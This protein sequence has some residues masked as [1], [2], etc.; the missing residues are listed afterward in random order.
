MADHSAHGKLIDNKNTGNILL[1]R[2]SAQDGVRV[3]ID[4]VTSSRKQ[5][6]DNYRQDGERPKVLARCPCSSCEKTRHEDHLE[7]DQ[8]DQQKSIEFNHSERLL[9]CP[10]KVLAF[11]L[12]DKSWRYVKVSELRDVKFRD[13]AFKNLVIKGK[14]KTVVKAMVRS[15]LSKEPGFTDLIHGKG[16]GLVL[17]LH[18]SPGTGK[19]LTAG[20]L[21]LCLLLRTP[22]C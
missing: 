5:G 18:G 8:V 17:L 15:Y 13:D 3:M 7:E 20:K 2:R 4:Y 14:H 19:T 11:S 21:P 1:T 6:P 9:C 12:R 22:L 16:R 10:S